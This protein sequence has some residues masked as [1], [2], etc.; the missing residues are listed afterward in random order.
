MNSVQVSI[1]LACGDAASCLPQIKPDPQPQSI[2]CDPCSKSLLLTGMTVSTPSTLG[3]RIVRH[4]PLFSRDSSLLYTSVASC[5]KIFR[6]SDGR[7]IRSV[8]L[9][10]LKSNDEELRKRIIDQIPED[11]V[12]VKRNT[13]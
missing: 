8:Q 1:E 12:L 5:L 13:L 2:C 9:S 11:S 10:P 7:L 4:P 6:V 3:G